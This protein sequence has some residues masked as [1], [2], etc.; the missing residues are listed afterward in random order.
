[1]SDAPI[2]RPED[3]VAT[4]VEAWNRCDPDV[5]A[6]LFDS[7]AEFVNVT[8]LWW[9]TREEIRKA[10]AYGL[11]RIFKESVLTATDV[12]VKW[13]SD[14]IAVVHARMTLA[15]QSPVNEISEP[16]QRG[17]VSGTISATGSSGRRRRL[18]CLA[19]RLIDHQQPHHRAGT[20]GSL[21]VKLLQQDL[22]L[23]LTCQIARPR[24][25]Y[26]PEQ[27]QVGAQENQNTRQGRPVEFTPRHVIDPMASDGDG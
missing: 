19:G 25:G 1:M 13:L 12:R 4:F 26:P 22:Q 21:A 15:G 16:R 14:E 8:G 10:H 2:G 7:D 24:A 3:V 20:A 27:Y 6:T 9:H 18:T 23:A 5:L 11:T 17:W